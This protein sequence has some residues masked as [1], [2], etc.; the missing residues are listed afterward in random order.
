MTKVLTLNN[1]LE[2]IRFKMY[3]MKTQ[4]NFFEKKI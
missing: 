4:N 2:I 3:M 1:T